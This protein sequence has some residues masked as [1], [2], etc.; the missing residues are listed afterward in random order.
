M[1]CCRPAA[2][3][4]ARSSPQS[5]IRASPGPSTSRTDAGRQ[6]PTPY[7]APELATEEREPDDRADVYSLGAIAYYLLTGGTPQTAATGEGEVGGD[8]SPPRASAVNGSV[9]GR[10][11]AVLETALAGEPGDR[12]A[13]PYE[14]KLATLFDSHGNPQ[15]AQQTAGEDSGGTAPSEERGGLAGADD[16]QP[17]RPE[18]GPPGHRVATEGQAPLV[19]GP[20]LSRV[21]G[22]LGLFVGPS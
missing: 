2:T 18:R 3:R 15:P 17:D 10:F 20:R 11:D 22:L 19:A 8:G 5:S 21:D 14:F 7:T 12:Y 16:A 1:G 9:P 4:Q 6:Q 13:T